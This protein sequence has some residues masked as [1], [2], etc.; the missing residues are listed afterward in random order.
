MYLPPSSA[1]NDF[2]LATLRELLVHWFAREDGRPYGL[3]L[4][5]ATPRAWLAH[6]KRVAVR[7]LPTP[8]G[9]ISYSID[10]RIGAGYLDAELSVPSRTR[11]GELRLRV[12]V[13]P[14]K[15]VR[16]AR[17]GRTTFAPDGDTF[18]LT[19]RTGRLEMRVYV[20]DRS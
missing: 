14:S 11:I 16:L 19:G 7:G 13:P 6:G 20:R 10:S 12:R 9:P 3:H 5:H 15:R 17:I 8:F 4:A 18:D 2:F 1:N